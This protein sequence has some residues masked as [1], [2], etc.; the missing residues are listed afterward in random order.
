MGGW[1]I[2]VMGEWIDGWMGGWVHGCMGCD[3]ADCRLPTFNCRIVAEGLHIG[4]DV[5]NL[6]KLKISF[7]MF[8]LNQFTP[9][10]AFDLRCPI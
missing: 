8:W 2:G 7:L 6:L 5:S 4:L 10:L 3:T 9:A 1:G